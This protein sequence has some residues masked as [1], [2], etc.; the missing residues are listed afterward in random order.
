MSTGHAGFDRFIGGLDGLVTG[1]TILPAWSPDGRSL[2]FL[3]GTAEERTGR[4]VDLESGESTPLVADV[5]VLREEV[6][7]A[8]GRSPAGRG[9]PFDHIAFTGPRTLLGVVGRDRVTLDL[10]TGDVR[11]V[12]EERAVDV[13]TGFADSVRRTPREFLRTLPMVDP[14]K[15]RELVSP[16]GDLFVSTEG[17]NVVLRSAA[18]GRSVPLT[19]DGTPE[20]EYRF[21]LVD[22]SMAMLGMAF[23]VCNWSPDGSRLAV[24]RVDNRG[25][26]QNPQVHQLKREAE[27]VLRY[28]PLAG[29][30]LERTTLHVLDVHGGA[31][32]ELDL[33]DTTDTYPVHAA[34][35]PDGTALVVFVLSRDCRRAEVLLAD[36][37]TG[38]TRSLFV[39]EG[40]TF[41]RIHHDVYFGKK[42]GLFLTPDGTRLL[43]LSERSG[44]KHLYQYD[45]DGN[46]VGQL[47]DG[48]WPVDYACRI[49]GE[50]VYFTAHLDQARPYD[51]HLARV[52]LVGGEVE[53]LTEHAGKHSVMFSP[54]GAVFVDT[55]STPA[56]AP[57]SVLRRN[58]GALLCELSTADVS[59]LEWT[60]PRE[61]TATAADGRTELWGTMFFPADFDEARTYPLVEYVY[62]GPQI[63]VVP[64]AFHD[65][66]TPRAQALAQLGFVTF[67][68]D[69][70]GTPERSKAF[71]DV[72]HR[73]W[74]GA[75][76]PDH[77]TVVEQLK[78]R[79]SFLSEAPVGVIGHSW[80]G[81]SAFRLAA[82]RPDVYTAAVS[83]ASGF[84]PYSSVLYEC[85]LGFPQTD[86]DA[87]RDAAVYP[88]AERMSAEFMLLCGTIDHS[89][90]SNNVTMSEALIRARKQHEFVVL[91][92]Q[93][94][95]YDAAH[96]SYYWRKVSDFFRTHLVKTS[97]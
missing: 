3:D 56:E 78:A 82:E 81:Y 21:D 57:R 86:A 18:D 11:K 75:L 35:L 25:V 31:P 80:G 95:S 38:A 20:H 53:H 54:D 32:V 29:G 5:Q 2:A 60:P 43:W 45:L 97:Q 51:L 33:G 24:H 34:W 16:D 19:A 91:P 89:T 85:Y 30:K 76:V 94:H 23:P 40:D 84:D 48:D 83:S 88:L 4:L 49:D 68:V 46:L 74:A 79:H 27:V 39:E 28:D 87:Y 62:G 96:N 52:P 70:R 37:R 77:A 12:P 59:R 90:W 71:H 8:T 72:V 69:G 92:G 61:F 55:W 67:V 22:P 47:T 44:W 13:H 41:L 58:D 10:D 63:A 1:G 17:G 64:R 9:L 73:D 15:V 42:I 7:K 93:P 66:F 36:A 26:Y 50:H 6:Q 14:M 65:V